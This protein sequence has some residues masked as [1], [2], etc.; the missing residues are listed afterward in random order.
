V[1]FS[2]FKASLVYRAS[3]RT[4]RVHRETLSQKPTNKQKN[5][6]KKRKEKK[7]HIAVYEDVHNRNPNIF[8]VEMVWK[9][10]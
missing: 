6:N 4:A 5:K 1:N 10:A 7:T 2:A 9:F 3:S 8:E